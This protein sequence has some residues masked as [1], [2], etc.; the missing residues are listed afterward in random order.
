MVL[1]GSR[2][3]LGTP[4]HSPHSLPLH[5]GESAMSL[6]KSL[7]LVTN[8][9]AGTVDTDSPGALSSADSGLEQ[10]GQR[11][12]GQGIQLDDFAADEAAYRWVAGM[13]QGSTL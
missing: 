9:E 4:A 3:E 1:G 8:E 12:A 2:L 10:E 6:L 11:E 7:P 5:T 13:L